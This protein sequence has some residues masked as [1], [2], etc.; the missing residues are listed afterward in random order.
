MSYGNQSAYDNQLKSTIEPYYVKGDVFQRDQRYYDQ[1]LDRRT[2]RSP[3]RSR[4]D[5]PAVQTRNIVS[6]NSVRQEEQITSQR[7]S[8]SPHLAQ[9]GNLI[10]AP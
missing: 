8:Q 6:P 10:L 4:V 5:Q 3:N 9:G 1:L 2:L 7:R